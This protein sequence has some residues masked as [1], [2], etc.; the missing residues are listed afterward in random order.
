MPYITPWGSIDWGGVNAQ[1]W[2]PLLNQARRNQRR[3]SWR[4]EF[5]NSAYGAN[6]GDYFRG[7][8]NTSRDVVER[9]FALADALAQLED[10]VNNT[11]NVGSESTPG[12]S[13]F[14]RQGRYINQL[15][16]GNLPNAAGVSGNYA[17][18][19]MSAMEAGGDRGKSIASALRTQAGRD[20]VT[21]AL[22]A[23][24]GL[25]TSGFGRLGVEALVN[26]A[27]SKAA[28]APDEFQWLRNLAGKSSLWGQ[29]SMPTFP[30]NPVNWNE[31]TTGSN[32]VPT[33]V[34]Y[35]RQN[36][37]GWAEGAGWRV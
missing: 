7:A 25:G 16:G 3:D 18:Q 9:Q 1:E 6:L 8:S 21:E 26:D 5:L 24:A 28:G 31:S 27:M 20:A 30:K 19:L 32:E 2:D 13:L 23:R 14:G 35:R 34:P 4:D 29:E 33:D 36:P 15:T 37:T 11:G 12:A 17:Q 10:L 22:T